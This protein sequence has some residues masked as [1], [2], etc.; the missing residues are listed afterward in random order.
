M[1]KE[2]VIKLR[3]IRRDMD[4]V[5]DEIDSNEDQLLWGEVILS[6][7]NTLGCIFDDFSKESILPPMYAD[8]N[9]PRVNVVR[10]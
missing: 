9:D 2:L 5:F 8:P 3:R 4:S 6:F 1:N 10:D 7:E